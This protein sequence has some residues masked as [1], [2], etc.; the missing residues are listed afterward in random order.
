MKHAFSIRSCKK[1]TMINL[2]QLAST[3]LPPAT[4]HMPSGVDNA[5]SV[6]TSLIPHSPCHN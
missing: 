3:S 5:V 2:T 6:S 4:C 1:Q